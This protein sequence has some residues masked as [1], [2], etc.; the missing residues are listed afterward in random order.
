MWPVRR[1]R[2]LVTWFQNELEPEILAPPFAVW[3]AR[4]QSEILA[5]RD[6]AFELFALGKYPEALASLEAAAQQAQAELQAR[7]AAFADALNGAETAYK[8]D[9]HE[10][11]VAAIDRALQLQPES[12]AAQT[13]N[14]RIAKLPEVL[15]AIGKA[16]VSRVE[17]NLGGSERF[18]DRL[19][20]N[21]SW[22][23]LAERRTDW[24]I[25]TE[26]AFSAR[27]ESGLQNV[28]TQRLKPARSD[29][30]AAR[31]IYPDRS[32]TGVLAAK[33]KALGEQLK[34]E[35][36]MAEAAAARRSDDWGC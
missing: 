32:E 12:G 11:A 34:F 19:N 17:N 13:L 24:T 18:D 4:A 23:E 7:N 5:Q 21:R 31:E 10:A 25:L 9:D 3:N 16:A 14:T 35:R 33:V 30:R 29:L 6:K 26:R 20:S 27:I 8:V 36:L 22:S 1:S 2:Q 15:S 28:L